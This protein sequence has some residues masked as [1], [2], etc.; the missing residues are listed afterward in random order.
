MRD[1]TLDAVSTART[2]RPLLRPLL[3]LIAHPGLFH[4]RSRGRG[5]GRQRCQQQ[6]SEY[7]HVEY[8]LGKK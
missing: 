6:I 7:L 1:L 3:W 5:E 2:G 8:L 4:G